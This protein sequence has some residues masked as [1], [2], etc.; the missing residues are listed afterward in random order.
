[1]I[2]VFILLLNLLIAMLSSSYQTVYDAAEQ[3]YYLLKARIMLGYIR[4]DLRRMADDPESRKGLE[5]TMNFLWNW[6]ALS[7]DVDCT[8]FDSAKPEGEWWTFVDY[9][10]DEKS[11]LE[12][13]NE[14]LNR[15]FGAS[16]SEDILKDQT[17]ELQIN[18]ADDSLPD[19]E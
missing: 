15:S 19:D 17:N 1:M 11:I 14:L 5:R 8:L 16:I 6:K 18:Q 12:E 3:Y 10:E 13:R 7:W 4:T 2:L 9:S